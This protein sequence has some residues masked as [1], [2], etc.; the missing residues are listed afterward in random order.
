MQ[1][2]MKTYYASRIWITG[3]STHFSKRVPEGLEMNT[4]TNSLNR[5][6]QGPLCKVLLDGK[7]SIK[8]KINPVVS[9]TSL[10]GK[11]HST[12]KILKDDYTPP[13]LF[14]FLHTYVQVL[15]LH[16]LWCLL[17]GKDQVLD[18]LVG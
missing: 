11:T 9:M 3:V 12:A 6:R 17:R 14:D 15:L 10:R 4:S 13:N 2:F 18:H 5:G 7:R 16:H 1:E 8:V